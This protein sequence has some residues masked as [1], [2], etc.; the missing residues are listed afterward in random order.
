MTISRPVFGPASGPKNARNNLRRRHRLPRT[1]SARGFALLSAAVLMA[2]VLAF[3]AILLRYLTTTRVASRAGVE[4][5]SVQEIAEAGLS[6]AIYC[7]NATDGSKCGGT[8]GVNFAGE[9]N[10]SFGG[11]TYTTV[12]TGS[13]T[14]R[15]VS[16]TGK[17]AKGKKMK[18]NVNAT[19]DPPTTDPG[20][21]YSLQVGSDGVTFGAHAAITGGPVYSQG[22]INCDDNSISGPVYVSLANGLINNCQV[23]GDAHADRVTNNQF[24]GNEVY[25][26]TTNTGN[27][28]VSHAYGS[29]ATPTL[30]AGPTL[31][32][33]YWHK[34]ATD[35][36]T[37]NGNLTQS[38][39]SF[40]PMKISGNL[41]I[42][43]TVTLNGP[44]WVT[45]TIGFANNAVLQ[46]N[47]AF[48]ANST[49]I[50]ADGVITIS[51]NAQVNGSG[52]A[53]SFI[54]MHTTSSAS[55][56]IDI[57]NNCLGAV[58]F[59]PN[60]N[61]NISNNAGIAAAAGKSVVIANNTSIDY[62]DAYHDASTV[63]L[64]ATTT[65]IW[66]VE[67]GTWRAVTP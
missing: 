49:L 62:R 41:T 19:N 66:R 40:G 12:V 53:K 56:A 59:A 18:V 22:S 26:K 20:L 11:G 6:K 36:G 44:L 15:T 45:G 55:P 33:T 14:S 37:N 21:A 54:M 35:G 43:G 58:F 25:Y 16:S 4:A 38:G 7:L 23:H 28:G 17:S 27:A 46:L 39:G 1:P 29:Q 50:T 48:G 5:A 52:N 34:A 63:L 3:S 2:L 57:S 13:G 64:A 67:N 60:G 47:P 9:S 30:P 42:G 51:N 24:Y 10:V 31:D 61:V 8:Y 65:R 32:L